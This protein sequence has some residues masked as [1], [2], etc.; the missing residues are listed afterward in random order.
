MG[1]IKTNI[2]GLMTKIE[3]QNNENKDLER[4]ML[5]D[6]ASTCAEYIC[7]V[8]NM[9]NAINVAKIRLEPEEYRDYI[10]TFD[11][12]RSVTHNGLISGVKVLNRLANSHNLAQI[13]A[14]DINNRIKVAEFAKQY[15]DELFNERR[16]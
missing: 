16:I 4:E 12:R 6:L 2:K 11:K 1:T 10:E 3:N 13:F 14:G 8:V 5:E 9:E 7:T 15:V